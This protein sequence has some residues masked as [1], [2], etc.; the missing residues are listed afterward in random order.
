MNS[1]NSSLTDLNCVYQDDGN[2]LDLGVIAPK[3]RI[4]F[5]Y[6]M[7]IITNLKIKIKI[8]KHKLLEFA[9]NINNQVQL[10]HKINPVQKIFTD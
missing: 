4:I 3:I 9:T 8:T 5:Q 10:H 2:K 7:H 1:I 6:D